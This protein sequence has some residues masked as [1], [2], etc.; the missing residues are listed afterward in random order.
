M[1]PVLIVED[2]ESV[3]ALVA[4]ALGREGI[5][6]HSTGTVAGAL[7]WLSEQACAVVL[8]DY[9]LPDALAWPVLAACQAL[10]ERPPG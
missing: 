5:P 7:A 1:N 4:L 2:D 8:L 3:V 9:R 10:P 6:F